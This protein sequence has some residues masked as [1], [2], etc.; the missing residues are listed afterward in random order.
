MKKLASKILGIF[1]ILNFFSAFAQTPGNTSWQWQYPKPQGNTLRDIYVF[2]KDTVVAVGDLGTVIKT[3]DGGINWDVRHHAGGTDIDLYSVCFTDKFNGWSVG[4]IPYSNK[5]VLLNTTDGGESWT[6]VKVDMKSQIDTTLPLLA[7]YFVD[8]D[9][10][11]A[12]G[13]DG[14]VLRTTDGGN[15][16]DIQKMDNYIGAYLDIFFLNAIT[17]T[18]KNT[19]FI[20]GSGYYGNEIYMTTDCGRSWQWNEQI[21]MP[22]IYSGF[23]DIQF[24]DK[25]NGFIAGDFSVF[26]KTTDG[27]N[28]WQQD[29][30]GSYINYSAYFTDSLN[31]VVVGIGTY[32]PFIYS[33]SDGGNNWE[34]ISSDLI[35]GYALNKVRFSDKENG[36]IVGGK[37]MIR[38]TTNGGKNWFAINQKPHQFNSI[39]F[40]DENTGWAVG[41]RTGYFQSETDSGIVLHTTNGG[42][43]WEE[44]INSNN[45]VI[46]SVYAFD[47]KNVIAVG[48]ATQNNLTTNPINSIILSTTTGGQIWETQLFDTLFVFNSIFFVNDSIG[49][50]TGS[51]LLKTTDKGNTWNKITTDTNEPRKDI[52]FINESTGW[53]TLNG[54]NYI[55]KTV[56]GGKNWNQQLVDPNISISSFHFINEKI[57]WVVGSNYGERNI[58]KTSDGGINWILNQ[59]T[60][61]SYHSSYSSVYFINENIGWAAGTY[62]YGSWYNSTIIKTTDSGMD[63]F[64][65]N[66]PNTVGISNVFPIN[67]DVCY[68]VGYDGIFKTIDGGGIVSIERDKKMRNN[69]PE[70]IELYQNYPN[71]FNPST[72]IEY[73]LSKRQHVKLQVFN[74]LGQEIKILVDK[75]Q[76]SGNYKITWNPEGIASGV[77]FYQL[78]TASQIITK[79]MLL[80]R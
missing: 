29:S 38:R 10:G 60:S 44:Q 45:L 27:G 64:E 33:T 37:G 6:E 80:I 1:L 56:N 23:Y 12:V 43:D 67:E 66:V 55:L 42:K 69:I 53:G 54:G 47:N 57:G 26:L 40:T 36:W 2:S 22:K 30:V 52:Q 49:W 31:G 63:W 74:I 72:I 34:E 48:E 59:G 9:T 77:Y 46:N 17:F 18:D 35:P 13:E 75:E 25:N 51:E 39:Y 28:T 5:S 61:S 3:T 70:Q 32:Y 41:G 76:V 78:R 11:I 24:V 14:V 8:K 7:V 65:Q 68:A 15:N 20:V 73:K 50:I 16:W 58:Y 62:Q 19:G 4:G 21:I 71:P 79:K